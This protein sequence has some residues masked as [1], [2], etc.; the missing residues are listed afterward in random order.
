MISVPIPN[1]PSNLTATL[2]PMRGVY[3][4]WQDNSNNEN[5]FIIE[6][7]WHEPFVDLDGN[8]KYNIGE[9]F[10]DVDGDGRW[11][12]KD[13][14]IVANVGADV[15]DYS[16]LGEQW[17]L[18]AGCVI[19][20]R[21]SAFNDG[22]RSAYS[23]EASVTMPAPP[24]APSQLTATAVSTTDVELAWIDNSSDEETFEIERRMMEIFDDLNGDG[25]WEPGE[26][27]ID[28]N[29]D[30]T[31]TQTHWDRIGFVAANI[32]AY[33]DTQ[34]YPNA[35]YYYRV[36]AQNQNGRSEYSNEAY[37]TTQ[38]E[39]ISIELNEREWYLK[40]IRL[41]D[42]VYNTDDGTPGGVPR[43][44]LKNTGNVDVDV[45]MTYSRWSGVAPSYDTLED[46]FQT[47]VALESGDFITIPPPTPDNSYP[48]AVI[49]RGFT[50][51]T[52]SPLRI[53]YRAPTSLSQPVE[54]MAAVYDLRAYK[55]VE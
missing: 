41:G 26:P 17:Y 23:N 1:A 27:F 36:C 30:G 29:G 47:A 2:T 38:L 8:G 53:L 28:A 52:E 51:N 33:S 34:L 49:R 13:W 31:W 35:N 14:N 48:P 22:G 16:F 44:I 19:S 5:G 50:A 37:V 39:R 20:F 24:L 10:T 32:T 21:V 45:V 55:A 42:S 54:K 25:Q 43:H 46:H 6:M 3:I 11:T 9:P 7:K 40:G 4:T 15:T 18:P 12:G